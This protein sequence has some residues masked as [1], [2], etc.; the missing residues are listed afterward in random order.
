MKIKACI[1]DLD[2][3]LLYTLTSI[4]YAG[5]AVLMEMGYP[6]EPEDAY[7]YYCGDGADK[8]VERI[9]E[10]NDD[11]DPDRYEA[12]CRLFREKLKGHASDGVRIYDGMKETLE[13]LKAKGLKLA[14]C[15]NK[16]ENSVPEVIYEMF[17][18]DLFDAMLGQSERIPRKP[19]PDMALEAARRLEADPAD[20]LYIG[21]T[22]TDMRCGSGAGM[23]TLGALW[24]YR[25]REELI[26][27][28]AAHL[29]DSP[30]EILKYLV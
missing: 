20:C 24:G 17:G 14:V 1:F 22:A 18:P 27:G 25:D 5:N 8:L 23:I 30:S 2:G 15:S 13:S 3:T 11:R 12:A 9:L 29:I 4:A 6:A 28:G 21:D 16:P 7:R 19:A 26:G 10:K